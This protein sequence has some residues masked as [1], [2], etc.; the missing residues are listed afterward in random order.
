MDYPTSCNP[1]IFP[2]R[3]QIEICQMNKGRSLRSLSLSTSKCWKLVF[4][5]FP[6][7]GMFDWEGGPIPVARWGKGNSSIKSFKLQTLYT[8]VSS[9]WS[10]KYRGIEL[11]TFLHTLLHSKRSLLVWLSLFVACQTDVT[12]QCDNI[13]GPNGWSQ[14]CSQEV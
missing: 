11:Q 7:M 6:F 9:Y 13:L 8:R 14:V 4:R 10:S 5:T 12:S 2:Y 1:S 3:P